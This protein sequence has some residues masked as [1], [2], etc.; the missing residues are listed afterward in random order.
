MDSEATSVQLA[1]QETKL[2]E[3]AKNVERL[4]TLSENIARMQERETDRDEKLVVLF[5]KADSIEAKHTELASRVTASSW[6]ARGVMAV[7]TAIV[8]PVSGAVIWEVLH[9]I[10]AIERRVQHLED[11]T[12]KAK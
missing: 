6:W 11:T 12:G 10:P 8:L 7:L 9:D 2:E 4:L 5:T 1:R 3:I